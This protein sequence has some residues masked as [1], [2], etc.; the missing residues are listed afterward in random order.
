[1]LSVIE[2]FDHGG[3]HWY[4]STVT[5]CSYGDI[6]WCED[7]YLYKGSDIHMITYYFLHD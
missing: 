7:K 3:S 6:Y 4:F 1:M 5:V 2:L